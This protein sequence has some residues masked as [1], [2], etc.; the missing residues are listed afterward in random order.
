MHSVDEVHIRV[1]RR[2]EEHFVT[3]GLSGSRVGREVS[4]S[5]VDLNFNDFPGETS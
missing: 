2:T 5:K 1:T 3:G 4:F